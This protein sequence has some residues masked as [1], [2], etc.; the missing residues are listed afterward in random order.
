MI[1]TP[2]EE[3]YLPSLDGLRAVSILLVVVSHFGLGHIVPGGFGVTI[4]FF[5]SGFI[6]TRLLIYEFETTGSISLMRFYARR[7][8]R[9]APALLVYI[10]L[11]AGFIY[12]ALGSING[13]EVASALLYAANY[14]NIFVGYQQPAPFIILWSLAI[15]EHYYIIY[16]LL[17]AP[18]FTNYKRALVL[19]GLFAATVL[20]WRFFLV[21]G[22][23]AYD[24]NHARVYMGT[25]TRID[26]IAYGALLA[27]GLRSSKSRRFIDLLD[28]RRTIV[29]STLL[30][31]FTFV[32]RDAYF[33]ETLR[34]TVQ[35]LALMPLVYSVV[36]S[37]KLVKIRSRFENRTLVYV[38]KLSYS[39]Y[40]YHWLGKIA[41]DMVATPYGAQW[42]FIAIPIAVLGSTF[43]YHGIERPML[44]IRHFLGSRAK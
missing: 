16:P 38:G 19:L 7:F 34:Y 43:S 29:A 15:E 37:P 17:A 24:E 1:P 32:Y 2:A 4:F 44:K 40:L 22:A 27:I 30:L 10:G 21:Y 23:G 12:L 31:L 5:L 13:A 6:I 25:D 14:Y 41:A 28:S 42:L 39:L 36:F 35:G 11:A 8:V 33:R 3:R 18:L 26:S 9:L 20:V